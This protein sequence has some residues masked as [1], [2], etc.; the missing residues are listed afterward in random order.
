MIN[1][2]HKLFNPHCPHCKEIDDENK[3]CL[4]CEHLRLML[5]QSNIERKQ[6]LDRLLNKDNPI[7][8][9]VA[10]EE[11]KEPQL[12]KRNIPWNVRR[13]MLEKEDREK[14]KLMRDAPKPMIINTE[15]DAL[16]KELGIPPRDNNA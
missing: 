7:M 4:S 2:F 3:V 9:P 15:I 5:E 14:A 1:F 6:L 8:I 11:M 10:P 16:E 13:Q 12:M